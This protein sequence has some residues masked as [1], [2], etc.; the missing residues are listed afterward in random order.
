[1]LDNMPYNEKK[2]TLCAFY[3]TLWQK[4]GDND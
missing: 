2:P 3:R 1:M 4:I